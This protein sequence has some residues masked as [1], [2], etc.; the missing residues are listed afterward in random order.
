ML[1]PLARRTWAPRGETPVLRAWD[2]HDRLSVMD[3]ITLA[4][5]RQRLGLY[6]QIQRANVRTEHVLGFLRLLRRHVRGKMVLIWDRGACHK[7]KP[8]RDYLERYVR[9]IR[10]E[11]LPPYAPDLNPCEQVWNHAKYSDLANF[12]AQDVCDLH[13]HVESSLQRQRAQSPLLHSF[14]KTA[15]LNMKRD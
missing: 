13:E 12:V 4:P 2:R 10:V 5:R 9:T 6:W 11:W 1:Q 7:G 15:R 8:V 14:F 3:A